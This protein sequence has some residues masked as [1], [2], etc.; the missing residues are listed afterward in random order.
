M[1]SS[2]KTGTT[3]DSA[4]AGI[5]VDAIVAQHYKPKT[6]EA[7]SN[8]HWLVFIPL[9]L[10]GAYL[11]HFGFFLPSN[12]GDPTAYQSLAMKMN[13]GFMEHYDIYNYRMTPRPEPK[14][15]VDYVWEEN[16]NLWNARRIRAIYHRPLHLQPPLFPILLWLSHGTFNRGD[17]Y[18]SVAENRGWEVASQPPWPFLQAQFYAVIVPFALSVGTLL[19]VYLFC[20]RFFSYR[21]GLFAVLILLA[22]PV[23]LAVGPKVYVDGILTFFTFLTLHWYFRSLESER[24]R[25][26]WGFAALAGIALGLSYLTKVTGVLF[27]F[28]I[29]AASLLHP[30]TPSGLF[31]KLTQGRLWIA[32]FFTL[33]LA[34]PWLTL[35]HHYYG[36][37]FVNTPADPEN[38]WYQYVFGRPLRAYPLDL[39][40][41][42][43]S[44]AL[45]AAYGLLT[46]IRP[47]RN[48][49]EATLFATAM[50]YLGMFCLFVKTGTAGIEDRYLLPIYPLLAVLTGAALARCCGFLQS[51]W[52]RR[53]AYAL[54]GLGL[55]ILGFRS[56]WIGLD[57]VFR[58]VVVFKPLGF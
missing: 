24:Y 21:E 56:A 46:W 6:P 27:A 57:S 42:V 1:D 17:P 49:K 20:L 5:A 8:F 4:G 43:P 50:F 14:G 18:S 44:L 34:S 12:I 25:G 22:S 31:D 39:L 51:P 23:D 41:F 29:L 40:W 53:S 52:L 2:L 35:M 3:T 55:G 10:L 9:L 38:P 15:I 45:G 36:S 16:P 7:P 47:R 11:R 32:G 13:Y 30:K 48:W 58:G 19:L 54:S 37:V 28:G 33:L 26:A